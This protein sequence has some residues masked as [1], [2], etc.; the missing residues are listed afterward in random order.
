MG[1]TLY[2]FT[3]NIPEI[4]P[5]L[6]ILV[7]L[8]GCFGHCQLHVSIVLACECVGL[9]GGR[10]RGL[11]YNLP[12]GSASGKSITPYRQDAIVNLNR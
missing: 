12:E 8:Q 11:H 4:L 5:S 7:C 10:R 3:A 6:G 2:C 9:Y 1:D